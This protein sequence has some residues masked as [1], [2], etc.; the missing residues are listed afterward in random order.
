MTS[1]VPNI[2]AKIV[3][4]CRSFGCVGTLWIVGKNLRVPINHKYANINKLGCDRLVNVYGAA[5]LYNLPLLILDYGTALTCD[6]ISGKGVLMG[7]L[8]IPGAEIALK[9]LSE[10][11]ALLPTIEF[12][13]KYAPFI[14]RDTQGG[15]KAGILQG[16]GAMTDGLVERFRR[17]FGPG[18][19]VIATGGL[20][21]VI[22]PYTRKID[23]LDPCLTLRS[24]GQVYQNLLKKILKKI[25]S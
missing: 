1:V 23:I 24:L 19:Q 6:Y 7:G 13:K 20:A 3:K 25:S 8:I 18:F 15:M 17:R 2:T 21:K 5:R 12:P 4:I 16:Y 14:G 10:K 11:A 22:S 9:A